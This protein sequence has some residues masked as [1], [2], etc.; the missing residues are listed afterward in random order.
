MAPTLSAGNILVLRRRQAKKGD[1]VVVTH[2]NF[3]TIVKRIDVNGDLSGD[4]RAS[5]SAH[6]LGPYDSTQLIGVAVLAITP[7]GLR[8]LSVRRSGTRASSSE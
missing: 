3:G 5:T 8:R 7:S 1:V 2:A 6:D 4:S